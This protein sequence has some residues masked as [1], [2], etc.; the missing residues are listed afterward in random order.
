ML[1][2]PLKVNS[3]L[4]KS[5]ISFLAIIALLAS[6]NFLSF[7]FFKTNIE[8][9]I[10]QNNRVALKTAADRY[11][12]HIAIIKTMLF[13]LYQ[14]EQVVSFGR[15]LAAKDPGAVN[16]LKPADI[17]ESIRRDIN[18]PFLYMD[19]VFVYYAA[20]SFTVDKNGTGD[21]ART[22]SQFYVSEPYTLGFWNRQFSQAATTQLH[23]N[24]LFSIVS[25]DKQNKQLIPM[26]VKLPG[27]P[28]MIIGMLDAGQLHESFYGNNGPAFTIVHSD[29]SVIFDSSGPDTASKPIPLAEDQDY[30]LQDNTYY[31][32]Y[33]SEETNLTYMTSVPYSSI[34]SQ[35]RKLEVTLLVLFAVSVAIAAA[36]SVVFSRRINAPVKQIIASLRLR[37]PEV[38]RSSIYEFKLINEISRELI[39][40]RN[41]IHEDLQS[42]TSLLTDFGYISKLKKLASGSNEWKDTIV[43]NRPFRIVLFQLHIRTSRHQAMPA[44][45]DRLTYAARECIDLMFAEPFPNSRTLQMESNQ[46]VSVV[47]GDDR[48]EL[49]ERTLAALKAIFDQ[50][51][52]HYAV[53][54]AVSSFY[55]EGSDF[56]LAYRET[57]ERAR[58]AKLQ[59]G[60]QLIWD[61]V[62][63]VHHFVFTAQEE[64]ELYSHLQEGGG[65]ACV[66]LVVR[67]LE[68][69][70]RK[71]AF[72]VQYRTFAQGVAAKVLK[73]TDKAKI[74]PEPAGQLSDMLTDLEDC[75]TLDDYKR[76]LESFILV[77]AEAVKRR[78]DEKDPVVEFFFAYLEEHY[79]EDLSLDSVADRMNMSSTYLSA[80]IKEKTGTNF[81]DHL[82]NVRIRQAKEMLAG[83]SMSIRD[84]GEKIGYR[85]DTSFI[86]MF[87]KSSG[88]TPG[89]YRK[90]AA[91]EGNAGLQL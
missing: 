77:A 64:Q 91:L 6:F 82:N 58:Q 33:D 45:P 14:N 81:S 52:G 55:P 37:S 88:L 31:F 86:R 36:A 70:A 19:N 35:I 78:R 30:T 42:K 24:R 75:F 63:E 85:N 67:M 53:T 87:K 5:L 83:T 8:R 65:A 43:Q 41:E 62:R 4:V 9:E 17:V 20:A 46:L 7:A 1:K 11:E 3:L 51:S 76:F 57:L 84:I 50:D 32:T 22:F 54:A 34:A 47:F 25:S 27:Y 23:P 66:Q 74:E 71:E 60:M 18:N 12:K 38:V 59:D 39:R 68:H 21:A 44:K 48:R 28:H 13:K 29:G 61:D 90:R 26:T 69:M 16:Y 79:S 73:V 40:E 80:Y 10:I 2:L 49:L 15:Q 89:D 72:R 56:N